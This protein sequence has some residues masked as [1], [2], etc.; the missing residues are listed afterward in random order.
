MGGEFGGGI[1]TAVGEAGEL[2]ACL[3]VWGGAGLV[4]RWC[5]GLWCRGCF[6]SEGEV[7]CYEAGSSGAGDGG[8]VTLVIGGFGAWE[9]VYGRRVELCACDMV[10]GDVQGTTVKRLMLR[11]SC[12]VSVYETSNQA[13]PSTHLAGFYLAQVMFRSR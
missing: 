10:A 5:A 3:R 12:C 9:E 6:E 8:A 1:C 13:S 11:A 2:A 4:L 7:L